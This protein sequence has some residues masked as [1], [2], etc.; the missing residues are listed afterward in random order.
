MNNL[1]ETISNITNKNAKVFLRNAISILI[2]NNENTINYDDA[3]LSSIFIHSSVELAIKSIITKKENFRKILNNKNVD[4]LSEDDLRNKFKNNNLKVKE[5]DNLKNYI[6]SSPKVFKISKEKI[7]YIEKFQKYRN[8]LTHL[9]YNFSEEELTEL[10]SDLVYIIVHV[11]IFLLCDIKEVSHYDFYQNELDSNS[12]LKLISN[13][14]YK[15]SM[16]NFAITQ[17]ETIWYCLICDNKT[18][19]PVSKYCY[20]CAMN[21]NDSITFGFIN[22][23]YCKSNKSVVYDK[24]NIRIN[25]NTTKALCLN[26]REDTYIYECPECEGIYDLENFG[27]KHCQKEKCINS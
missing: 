22:C 5:F 21:F 4:K 15:D 27:T 26:C 11:I 8:K 25:N 12:F 16:V 17:T 1:S 3:I 2:K 7:A 23:K 14:L 6:K 18:L 13:P 10:K 20:T 24:L 19:N 9:H